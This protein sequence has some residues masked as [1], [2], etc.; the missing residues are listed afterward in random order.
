MKALRG[1]V[2]RAIRRKGHIV[3]VWPVRREV[4]DRTVG[5][6]GEVCRGPFAPLV[7]GRTAMV[8]KMERGEGS[9]KEERNGGGS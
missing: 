1:I 6:D 9:H 4:G 5:G 3:R 2:K 7:A 8:G